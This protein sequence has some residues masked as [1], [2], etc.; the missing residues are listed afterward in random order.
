MSTNPFFER[1]A[2]EIF[3][4]DTLETRNSDQLDFFETSVWC[5]KEA[6]EAAFAAGQLSANKKSQE[7]LESGG[8]YMAT[9]EIKY[10]DLVAAFGK[11]SESADHKTEAQWRILF[12]K[13]QKVEIYNYKNSKSYSS[14]YPDIKDVTVWHVGGCNL[15]LVDKLLGMLAGNAK[16]LNMA[17]E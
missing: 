8:Q 9:I 6:L 11:P 5:V 10:D 2:K 12:P 17:K 13:N 16:V 3:G 1:I 15:A 4:V 14:I 7:R